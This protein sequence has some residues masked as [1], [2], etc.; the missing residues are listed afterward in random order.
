MKRITFISLLTAAALIFTLEFF[1]FKE[2]KVYTH[3]IRLH[4]LANSDSDEDIEL[5]YTIR[6]EIFKESESVFST[7]ENSARAKEDMQNVGKKMTAIAN[8]VLKEKGKTYKA[9]AVWGTETYPERELDG[10]LLPAG[11]YYSLRIL[12]GEGEGENW[13]CVLFPPL[14]IGAS[15]VQEGLEGIGIDGDSIKTFTNRSAKYKFKFKI[16]EW[17]FG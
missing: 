8:R 7:Y 9:T 17:I 1:P 2:R 13:W 4:I 12:L 16:L 6:D 11:E 3:L 14:C 10:L 5:K 15:K